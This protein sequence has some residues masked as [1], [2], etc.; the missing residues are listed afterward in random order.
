V[1][2]VTKCAVLGAGALWLSVAI[3]AIAADTPHTFDDPVNA[4][5]YARLLE[6]LRCLVCQNQSLADS[7][8]DLAQDLRNEVYRMVTAGQDDR[9]IV[10]FLVA[11]YGDFVL[12]RPP[13][14]GMTTLLW[15]GPLLLLGIAAAVWRKMA[16]RAA[17][18]ASPLDADERARLQALA[19]HTDTSH[20]QRR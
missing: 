15:F 7:H 9:A 14:K 6:E 2:A 16:N 10:D 8:A 11:R 12:Y 19:D 18:P 4:A 20:E 3:T 1:N 17:T 13:L 5:R